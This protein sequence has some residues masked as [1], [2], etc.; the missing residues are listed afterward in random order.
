MNISHSSTPRIAIIGGGFSGV[1]TM[2]NLIRLSQGPM[3]LISINREGMVGRGIAYGTRRPEHLLNVAA[4]NM[5]AFPDLPDHFLQW[6]RT[7]SEFET[8]PEAELR[9]RFVPR[10]IYGDYVKSL[11]HHY[12][13]AN[14]EV[15][16]EF[17]QGTV[18][19]IEEKVMGGIIHLSDGSR[20]KADRVVLAT[21]N[22]LPAELPGAETLAEHP[23]WVAN[24]WIGWEKNLPIHGGEIVVLGTGLTT[25]DAVITLR[26]LGWQGKVHAVSRHGW[27]P[28]SHFRGIEYPD[29]P[30][31]N[32]DLAELGLTKL[33]LL[34]GE[35][36]TQLRELGANPAIV[37]DKMRGHT[38][39]IWKN[40]TRD[41]RLE[42]MRRYAAKWNILRH[43]IAPEIHA[44]VTS[45][46]LTGQ[47]E[48]HAANIEKVEAD[49]NGVRVFLDKGKEIRGDL[50]INATG[51]STRISESKSLLLQNLMRRGLVRP[52]EMD[53]GLKIEEDHIAVTGEERPSNLLLAIGPLLRG[54]FWETVAVPELRGQAKRVAEALLGQ[55]SA[56]AIDLEEMIEYYI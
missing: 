40:F 50:V 28:E 43:R 23:G 51:P 21:G 15:S 47:L 26:S 38:Q 6:L 48:L 3:H 22:E 46:H 42:F 7:R 4:R 31:E 35:H 16:T 34:I 11:L 5:S 49:G 32:I 20:I 36:C 53:M 10:M 52:D 19:D 27:L 17:V 39:R 41:E 33:R 55:S 1:M 37:V 30:P 18:T 14:T 56:A 9:E 2:V 24:P 25:V 29:F 12:I 13:S 8:L 44:Q 54:T 45:A